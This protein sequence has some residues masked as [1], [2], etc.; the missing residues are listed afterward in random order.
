MPV[1]LKVTNDEGKDVVEQGIDMGLSRKG[2]PNDSIFYIENQ[3]NTVA[4]E[5]TLIGSALHSLEDVENNV[6]SQE[7]YEREQLAGKWK[8]FSLSPD[9]GF[10]YELVLGDINAGAYL[11]GIQTEKISTQSEGMFPY[12]PVH[13]NAT[14]KFIDNVFVYEKESNGYASMRLQHETPSKRLTRHFEMTFGLG[15]E[16]NS[17]KT[18]W[19]EAIPYVSI[20][21]RNNVKGDGLGYGFLFAYDREN[22]SVVVSVQKDMVGITSHYDGLLVGTTLFRTQNIRLDNTR[23]FTIKCYDDKA[24]NNTPCFEVLYGGQSQRLYAAVGDSSGNIMKDTSSSAYKGTG[25]YY[26]EC[27]LQEG[28]ISVSFRNM[29]I[30]TDLNKQPIYVRTTIDDRAEDKV[31]YNSSI[32]ISYYED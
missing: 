17:D 32:A 23:E 8:Q 28:D 6:I 30:T 24:N 14:M 15:F 18:A 9:S 20:P 3:G 21:V 10:Q 7:E 25:Y 5:V 16:V 19:D 12:N 22:N 11:T 29:S 31:E 13:S 2:K 1:I 4:R 27:T 26:L